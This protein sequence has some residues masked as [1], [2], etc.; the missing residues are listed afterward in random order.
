MVL[1]GNAAHLARHGSNDTVALEPQHGSRYGAR[2]RIFTLSSIVT[3]ALDISAGPIC[4]RVMN[5]D[6]APTAA[7][8]L[9][10]SW[11]LMATHVIQSTEPSSSITLGHQEATDQ[12]PDS[13]HQ[14]DLW[15]QHGSE[16]SAQIQA[17][18]EPPTQT[19]SLTTA[20]TGCHHGP[21]WHHSL[22]RLEWTSNAN[23]TLGGIPD[24][25]YPLSHPWLQESR[26]STHTLAAVGPQTQTHP[27]AVIVHQ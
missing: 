19:W 24:P 1:V 25:G 4:G 6:M 18:E 3:G 2:S 15:W 22:P 23:L 20:H 17:V 10:K 16:T 12:G 14:C 26:K 5:A 9:T 27:M 7:Q 11:F 13:G 8:V 21:S